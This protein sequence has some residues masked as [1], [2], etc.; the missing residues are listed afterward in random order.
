MHS[1]LQATLHWKIYPGSQSPLLKLYPLGRRFHLLGVVE[2]GSG[3]DFLHFSLHSSFSTF[4]KQRSH[5]EWLS[6]PTLTPLGKVFL[7]FFSKRKRNKTCW[8]PSQKG[9]WLKSSVF[10]IV[11]LLYCHHLDPD[12]DR[13]GLAFPPCW[14]RDFESW[15]KIIK[16]PEIRMKYLNVTYHPLVP[17]GTFME[18]QGFLETC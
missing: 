9:N 16:K 10:G 2:H 3:Q 12:R 8:F 15:L 11:P 13:V 17:Q 1:D 18:L 5:L 6:R 14:G 4:E 7:N